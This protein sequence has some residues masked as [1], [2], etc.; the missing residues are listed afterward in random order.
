MLKCLVCLWH[1][2]IVQLRKWSFLIITRLSLNAYILLNYANYLFNG[3]QW[4]YGRFY[5]YSFLN[6][7]LSR[8]IKIP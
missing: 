3:D 8:R 2:K 5:C 1:I 4:E 6:F 7:S